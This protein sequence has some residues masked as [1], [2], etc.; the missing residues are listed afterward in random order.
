M[1]ACVV[2]LGGL[3]AWFGIHGGGPADAVPA[4]LEEPPADA[5][6]LSASEEL[7]E[8]EAEPE[9]P[10]AVDLRQAVLE[11]GRY[12]QA[13]ADGTRAVFTLDPILQQAAERSLRRHPLLH[14]SVVAL[15]PATGRVLA[16]A[17]RAGGGSGARP[18][19]DASSP[20]ASIFKV[21]SAA[22]L[23]TRAGVAPGE[24]VCVHGGRRRL[25]KSEIVGDAR[26]DK[27]CRRFA[28][29]LG[30]SDNGV[31]ARLAY[32][33]L[34]PE[35]LEDVALAFGFNRTLD[36][37][38]DVP[39]STL[40]LP[41]ADDRLEYARTAAG[42]W[43]SRLSPLH[44]ALLAA[45]VANDGV[46]LRPWRVAEWRAADGEVIHRGEPRPLGRVV[47]ERTAHVLTRMMVETS[48]RG[49][50]RRVF[51]HK[52][53]WPFRIEVA[54]KTGSLSRTKP[55]H[56]SY[57]W[58]V[59]FAPAEEPRIA[60]AT[61]VAN[62]LRWYVKAIHVA[63]DTLVAFFRAEQARERERSRNVTARPSA[64]L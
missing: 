61:L 46:M 44:A 16:L 5:D 18:A 57:S 62:P 9:L 36:L 6:R 59:A 1:V 22:A 32:H 52:R 3:V 53:E 47:D 12:V 35:A 27:Q 21:V 58:F 19:F 54:A 45:T 60:V 34:A 30:H 55:S 63:R 24:Q 13:L 2:A 17:E 4:R 43:H 40:E 56:V 39:P 8:E 31:F 48:R 11:D 23:L 28:A 14:G 37:P 29:A 33:R 41:G 38:W 26:R 64:R 7:L 50:G 51:A 20:A 42:F 10:V 25:R 15:E 49:T